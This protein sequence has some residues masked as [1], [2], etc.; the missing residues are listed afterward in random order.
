MKV[1]MYLSS[2]M[3]L[4]I[5]LVSLWLLRPRCL[6]TVVL[7]LRLH[8]QSKN[9]LLSMLNDNLGFHSHFLLHL[10]SWLS[11][12]QCIGFSFLWRAKYMISLFVG[13]VD[14]RVTEESLMDRLNTNMHDAC[15]Q[16]DKG[17]RLDWSYSIM[18]IPSLSHWHLYRYN[19][20]AA[21]TKK[22]KG[23]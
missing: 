19:R 11:Q 20:L 15:L 18:S 12:W 23:K 13:N 7:R 16:I 22:G 4:Y 8:W 21:K 17:C 10:W 9:L 1:R 6:W 3:M 5:T 2:A 14:Y